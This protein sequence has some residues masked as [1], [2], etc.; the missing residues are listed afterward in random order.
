[1]LKEILSIDLKN[2]K[3][4]VENNSKEVL[5]MTN[6]SYELYALELFSVKDGS[7]EAIVFLTCNIDNIA[8]YGITIKGIDNVKYLIQSDEFHNEFKQKELF[9]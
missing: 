9:H 2:K 5:T 8:H 3:I 1:M 4:T 6:V 7:E